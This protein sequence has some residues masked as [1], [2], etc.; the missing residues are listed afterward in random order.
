MKKVLA[1]M[2]SPRKS[3]N[4]DYLLDY[5]LDGIKENDVDVKKIYIKDTNVNHC[6]G[7]NYCGKTGECIIKDDV[8]EIYND[9]DDSDIIIFASPIY[10]NSVSG[11]SKNLIDRC[12]K[13]WSIK[14]S[15][16]KKYEPTKDRIGIFLSTAGAAFDINQFN[17]AVYVTDYFFKAINVKYKGNYFVTDTD[18][19]DIKD[20][21]DIK[22][23]LYDIGKNILNIK[24]FYIQK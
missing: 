24:D 21:L 11:L 19:F 9:F 8:Q 12:Q 10:F 16:N 23:E 1:L 5:I 4:T 15:L 20:R 17:G 6:T 2:G 18:N 14:Y 7:C 13:Y 22:E 3:K